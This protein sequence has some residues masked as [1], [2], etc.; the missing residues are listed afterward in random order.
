VAALLATSFLA[1]A[2]IRQAIAMLQAT[3]QAKGIGLEAGVD[4][5]IPFLY[6]DPN[7][8]LQVLS[9]L[10]E[11][12]IKFTPN[13]GSVMVKACLTE[14]D[15]DFV[16]VSVTDTGRGIS[17]EAKALIFE[18]LYQDPNSID[19]SRKG[20]GLG[21]YISKEL[22]RLHG[23][24]IW[25][26]SQLSHGSTFVFTLPLFSLAK[27]LAPII[28]SQGRLRPALSL[29]SVELTPRVTPFAGNW[30][31][32]RQHC[33]QML[34]P[35]ILGD[36][37][38]ILPALSRS[39]QGETLVIVASTDQHGATVIEKRIRQQLE[40][41]ERLQASC[42][43]KLSSVALK[44][45]AADRQEPVEKLVQEVADSITEMTMATLRQSLP[46]A[47]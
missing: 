43:F 1:R 10:V 2:T 36:K 34:E 7:R 28:T 25:V 31:D 40:R 42:A 47:N 45:P 22:V 21:L 19:D 44:L 39:G 4:T 8:V 11:N 18:R 6:A 17:P 12:A 5:R 27:F 29:I 30:Q 26:E 38:A 41:S 15:P 16:H 46:A 32:I 23:G 33:L 14:N 24:Q 35:C 13:D 20:L 9:N 3:A 37:D